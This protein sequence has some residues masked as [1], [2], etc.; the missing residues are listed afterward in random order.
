MAEPDEFPLAFSET[1]AVVLV[2]T[3]GALVSCA[4]V[5]IL[6]VTTLGDRPLVNLVAGGV[7]FLMGGF[8]TRAGYVSARRAKTSGVIRIERDL[9]VE[10]GGRVRRLN[11]ADVIAVREGLE[12]M[13]PLAMNKFVRVEFGDEAFLLGPFDAEDVQAHEETVRGWILE[14]L[15]INAGRLGP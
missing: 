5:A 4:A 8:L 6:A 11:A 12:L 13:L 14:R 2:V 7:G 9:V 1:R 10:Q 15:K 3:S